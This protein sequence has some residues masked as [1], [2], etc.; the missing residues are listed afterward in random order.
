MIA[1]CARRCGEMLAV[2]ILAAVACGIAGSAPRPASAA[3]P[4]A[5][6]PAALVPAALVPAGRAAITYTSFSPGRGPHAAFSSPAVAD[7]T[8]DSV[9][10]VVVGGMDG[11]VRAFSLAGAPR[12]GCLW[13]G[14]AAVQSSPTLVDWDGDGVK[15]I[16]ASSVG[17]GV[18]GWRGDGT[19]LFNLPTSGGV[20]STPA[21]GDVDGDG[22]LDIAVSTWAHRITV[23]RHN[24]TEMFS[25][26]IYD[27]S[28]ST[29]ALADL[30]GDG[31]LEVIV[32]A[33]MD[34]I[35][36]ATRLSPE[37]AAGGIIWAVH[38]DGSDVLGFPRHL[39]DQ[40]IWSSP[41][42]VDLNEDGA[43]DIVVGTGANFGRAV[44][45]TLFALDRRGNALPGWPVAMPG[46]TM[47][48]PAIADLDGDGH[49]DVAQQAGD[50]SI[51][52]INRTGGIWKQ[53][54]NRSWGPC[55]PA[56]FDGGPSVGDINGDGVQD[57][58]SV[59][60]AH[61]RVHNGR[62]GALEYENQLPNTWVPGSHPTIVSYAG[63][64]YVVVTVTTDANGNGAQDVGDQQV[65]SIFR[66]GQAAGHLAWP[67][68]HQNLAHTGTVDDRIRPSVSGSLAVPVLDTTK[69]QVNVAGVDNETGIRNFDVDVRTDAA[70]PWARLVNGKGP[71]GAPGISVT[72]APNLFGLPG[73][74]YEVR[75]RSR[76]AAGN[77]SSWR[78]LGSI[79][80]PANAV[81]SQPFRAAYA[82]SVSGAV[83]AVSSP[84]VVGPG[85]IG[86][87]GRGIAAAAAGGGYTLDGF[88]GIHRFG[89]APQLVGTTYWPGWDIARGIAL[90]ASGGGGLVLDGF[91]GLH[92]F[93]AA[94]LPARW[95]A[96]WVGWDVA[97][98]VVLTPDSTLARP[99]GYVLDAFGGVH[100]FGGAPRVSTGAYWPGS[101]LARGIAMDPAGPGG[102]VLDAWGGLH[103]FG[104]APA[105]TPPAYWPGQDIAR[106]VALIGGG[107]AG[108]GYVLDHAGGIW[109]FGGAPRVE[110][111][112]YWGVPVARGLS[113]AP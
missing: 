14:N 40:V 4:A 82:G 70:G 47:G 12:I 49:L 3:G 50:G 110:S 39:S 45:R 113:I 43:L 41:A 100:G 111:T 78:V 9:P 105:R 64:A 22:Q 77:R 68:F 33:D 87:L 71:R 65:T 84:P 21:V 109:R 108:R 103:A 69:I 26:L 53:W 61:L 74:G 62:T 101:D 51:S 1:R 56:P 85:I 81:R 52:Y 92:P 28:W 54:C 42:V 30:D 10:E 97:R 91:G 63:D 27:T 5:L 19:L 44:G 18:Y 59:T 112:A 98:G 94:K 38:S 32:G 66:T 7:V 99:R 60:E 31:K 58:V 36:L 106:G 11:C 89:G 79:A 15:D 83:A 23:F 95:S 13:V 17:G 25:R 76:D 8:G 96:P 107:L 104:G 55:Q 73:H 90:D 24:G 88:G 80:I 67:M 93:G 86:R 35:N 6:I 57:V 34:P 48:S 46:V 72:M 37:L 75:A 20:L 16:I 29:P 2:L 102:Y